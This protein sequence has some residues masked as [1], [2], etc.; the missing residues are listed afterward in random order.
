MQALVLD[1]FEVAA[2]LRIQRATLISAMHQES[3]DYVPRPTGSISG[4]HFWMRE[5]FEPWLAQRSPTKSR[6][7][8]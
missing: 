7:P 4:C 8:K 2:T 5:D 6:S 3:W 1:V